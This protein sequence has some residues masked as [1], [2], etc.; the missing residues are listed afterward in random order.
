MARIEQAAQFF[1]LPEPGIDLVEEKGG[2]VL[3]DEA[4]EDG[5]G[6]I[7]GAQCTGRERGEQVE[8]GG[9]AAAGF[10]GGD[11]EAGVCRK[12]AKAWVWADQSVK[13][14]AAPGGRKR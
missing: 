8:G 1:G 12:A 3:V 10:G 5:G 13:A 9:F 2:L 7:F 11:V 14:S 6:E 4:E